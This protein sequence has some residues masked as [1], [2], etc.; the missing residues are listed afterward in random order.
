MGWPRSGTF[1]P[2]NSRSASGRFALAH[3]VQIVLGCSLFSLLLLLGYVL[4]RIIP[5]QQSGYFPF[6]LDENMGVKAFFT[7]PPSPTLCAIQPSARLWTFNGERMDTMEMAREALFNK[8]YTP[9]LL[10]FYDS[11]SIRKIVWW[12][13]S[14]TSGEIELDGALHIRGFGSHSWPEYIGFLK[15][16]RLTA[17]NGRKVASEEEWKTLSAAAAPLSRM[18]F[19]DPDL[20]GQGEIDLFLY[21]VDSRLPWILILAGVGFAGLG[22]FVY[23]VN[24]TRLSSWGFLQFTFY[25]A[26][27]YFLRSIPPHFRSLA[28]RNAFQILLFFVAVPSFYF[29]LTFTPLQRIFRGFRRLSAA[30]LI[31]GLVLTGI[32]FTTALPTF[33]A[34]GLLMLAVVGLGVC[35][36]A[37]ANSKV[38][39][40]TLMDRQHSAIMSMAIIMSFLP[41]AV[42]VVLRNFG[43]LD[44]A[45]QVWFELTP[46]LFPIVIG[47]AIAQHNLLQISDLVLEGIMFGGLTTAVGIAYAVVT[48]S[49]IPLAERVF[50]GGSKWV[51]AIFVSFV[52]LLFSPVYSRARVYLQKRYLKMQTK[53][54][55]FIET[56]KLWV[57]KMEDAKTFA[58]SVIQNLRRLGET[59]EVSILS[60]AEASSRLSVM[61]STHLATDATYEFGE[62]HSFSAYLA[63][64]E[65]VARDLLRDE[66]GDVR[67]TQWALEFIENIKASWLFPLFIEGQLYAVLAM[68]EKATRRNYSRQ[69]AAKLRAVAR[70]IGL[71]LY[72]FIIRLRM[73]EKRRV[74][75]ALN[76]SEDKFRLLA[77]NAVDVIFRHQL[78]PD[79]GMEYISPSIRDVALRCPED[80]YKSPD[81]F[82]EMTHTDDRKSIL[83]FFASSQ[84][85]N[86]IHE[87][88]WRRSDGSWVWVEQR[89][90]LVF[91]EDGRP[92]ACEGIARD[93]TERKSAERRH[94]DLQAQ[95]LQS[96]KLEAVG[97][98]ASGIAHDFSNLLTAISGFTTLAKTSLAAE[99]PALDSLE[100]V[101][102]AAKQASGI[103]KSLLQFT[104]STRRVKTTL[105]LQKTI[106]E[107]VRMMKR[108]LPSSIEFR[109]HYS[110]DTFWIKADETQIYQVIM[111][112]VINARDALPSGGTIILDTHAGDDSHVIVSLEDTG[113][114]MTQEIARQIFDPFFTTKSQDRGSGLGLSIVHGIVKDHGG[115]IRVD[116]APERGSKFTLVFPLDD[117]PNVW[118]APLHKPALCVGRRETILLAEDEPFVRS[119][120]VSRFE[121]I[122]FMVCPLKNGNE[123]MEFCASESPTSVSLAIM[124]Y[125]LPGRDG[126]QCV[127]SLRAR[128]PGLP[129]VLIT[130][131]DVLDSSVADQYEVEFLRKPFP[132]ATLEQWVFRSLDDAECTEHSNAETNEGGGE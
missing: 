40:F 116:T 110:E 39:D 4:T 3:L 1:N 50:P 34:W 93:I 72:D 105:H 14:H 106:R 115:D 82:L 28:E 108:V 88:R 53:Y 102:Q 76:E 42:Y 80:F 74:E 78:A 25:L 71:G 2:L 119:A 46:L 87:V 86:I 54:D 24:P 68:G 109:E 118:S 23:W 92:F 47:Y 38:S 89:L 43:V 48:S 101:E 49:V 59:H 128:F 45:W 77:E 121:D 31:S 85:R 127:T 95:L 97:A 124:D 18:T 9:Q 90:I 10:E 69:E 41:M 27:F 81:L 123:V 33:P 67:G 94:A 112:L 64:S 32:H 57:E 11:G 52:A 111:N 26:L 117:P 130:G 55:E 107:C 56:I 129:I 12:T 29:Y 7:F 73:A 91:D 62:N 58:S 83:D 8:R 21:R 132:L 51:T 61:A 79:F 20:Q 16:Y 84:G 37:F 122:G 120:L 99:H 15:G 13:L 19:Q 114:G 75:K 125:D 113:V 35:M 126:L 36:P 63:G 100:N 5:V 60:Y 17:F 65:P 131:S 70:E 66:L 98:L 44:D 104:Q 22:L 6:Q 103:T 96:Q 30:G